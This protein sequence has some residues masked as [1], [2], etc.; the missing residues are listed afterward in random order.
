[1]KCLR[2]VPMLGFV[3]L[4]LHLFSEDTMKLQ[5]ISEDKTEYKAAVA[6]VKYRDS[7]LLGLSTANDDRSGK[8]CFPGGGINSGESPKKAAE[9]ECFE[10]LGVKCKAVG[11]PFSH[12]NKKHVAFVPCKIESKKDKY[13]LNSEFS[14]AG[15]F[16]RQELR[17]LKLHNNVMQLISKTRN[18]Y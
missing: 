17:N 2:W 12:G 1:M 4:G 10:E 8:W 14:A 3:L 16:D 15:L 5:L 6:V 9:R 7:W 18:K 13:V 11:E